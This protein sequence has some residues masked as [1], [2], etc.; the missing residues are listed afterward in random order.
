VQARAAAHIGMRLC[1]TTQLG[2]DRAHYPGVVDVYAAT[3]KQWFADKKS[4]LQPT[5]FTQFQNWS[6]NAQ[7]QAK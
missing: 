3:Q 7:K 1:A 2:L 5:L 4:P 6:M